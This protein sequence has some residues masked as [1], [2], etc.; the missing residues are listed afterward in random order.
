MIVEKWNMMA[1][2]VSMDMEVGWE[3]SDMMTYF[4]CFSAEE[5]WED[6]EVKQELKMDKSLNTDLD[7]KYLT[8]T[9][10]LKLLMSKSNKRA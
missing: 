8:L 2:K 1:I 7:D 10:I 4:K 3:G 6:K 9:Q 5:E